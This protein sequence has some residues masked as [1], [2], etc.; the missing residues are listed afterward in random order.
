MLYNY[1]KYFLLLHRLSFF[2]KPASATSVNDFSTN[3]DTLKHY[4]DQKYVHIVGLNSVICCVQSSLVILETSVGYV[5]NATINSDEANYTIAVSQTMIV[6]RNQ[7]TTNLDENVIGAKG[8]NLSVVETKTILNAVTERQICIQMGIVNSTGVYHFNQRSLSTFLTDDP[9]ISY[10]IS[11]INENILGNVHCIASEQNGSIIMLTNLNESSYAPNCSN[12]ANLASQDA[13]QCSLVPQSIP[14]FQTWPPDAN[15]LNSYAPI[16]FAFFN[17]D[18]DKTHKGNLF[19]EGG[20]LWW[21]EGFGLTVGPAGSVL[22]Y[23]C[24]SLS[25][26]IGAAATGVLAFISA[27]SPIFPAV[28]NGT[29]GTF[30][31]TITY[32][33]IL[34]WDMCGMPIFLYGET[35]F[36]ANR[37]PDFPIS[38]QLKPTDWTYYPIGNGIAYG[39][40]YSHTEP[41]PKLYTIIDPIVIINCYDEANNVTVKGVPVYIN[42]VC[43]GGTG[44]TYFFAN[45]TYNMEFQS[46]GFDYLDVNGTIFNNN[47]ANVDFQGEESDTIIVT[48]YFSYVPTYTLTVD[49]YF[50]NANNENCSVNP[51]VYVDGELVGTAPISTA[52]TIGFHEIQV[53]DT[54][55]NDAINN[56][57]SLVQL[58]LNDCNGTHYFNNLQIIRFY[59]N[60][61]I[62]GCYGYRW[63]SE[64]GWCV[65]D[66]CATMTE[67]PLYPLPTITGYMNQETTGGH[68]YVNCY[69]EGDCPTFP[70]SIYVT[71]NYYDWFYVST[72]NVDNTSPQ[73]IDCGVTNETF[74]MI[75]LA[76]DGTGQQATLNVDALRVYP[77]RDGNLTLACGENGSIDP[78]AGL[79]EDLQAGSVFSATAYPDSGYWAVWYLNNQ[80]YSIDPSVSVIVDGN[81][82]LQV[83]FYASNASY[84][85]N[86]ESFEDYT[87]GLGCF[88]GEAFNCTTD[89]TAMSMTASVTGYLGSG[90]CAIYR[91]SDLSFVAKTQVRE[92]LDAGW[93]TF[94]FTNPPT[95]C[96][97]ETYIFVFAGCG[98]YGVHLCC[99]QYGE[100]DHGYAIDNW[101]SVDYFPELLTNEPYYTNSYRYSIYCTTLSLGN[102]PYYLAISADNGTTSPSG[103]QAYPWNTF[104]HV[105]ANPN[106]N[107]TFD[108]W[109]LDSSQTLYSNPVSLLMDGNHTLEAHFRP[110]LYYNLTVSCGTGGVSPTS[111]INTYVENSTVLMIAAP[112][113]GYMFDGWLLDDEPYSQ[114]SWLMVTMDGNHVLQANFVA[115]PTHT[116]TMSSGTGGTTS[117]SSGVHEYYENATVPVTAYPAANYTFSHWLLDNTQTIYNAS[118][119]VTMDTSHTLEAFFTAMPT[120]TLTISS[121]GNGTTDPSGICQYIENSQAQVTATAGEGSVFDHWLKDSQNAG[122]NQ[123]ITVTMDDDYTLEAVFR[124]L[125]YYDLAVSANGNGTTTGYALG[126]YQILE[127]STLQITAVPDEGFQFAGWLLDEEPYSQNL[128]VTL[129]MDG[130]H[131]LQ[132]NFETYYYICDIDSYS[133]YVTDPENLTGASNDDNWVCLLTYDAY[134]VS[135]TVVGVTDKEASG[136]VWV[137]GYVSSYDGGYLAVSVSEDGET[138]VQVSDQLVE[139]TTAGWI[140]CGVYPLPF[141]YVNLTLHDGWGTVSFDSVRIYPEPGASADWGNTAIFDDETCM[142]DN[143]CGEI[144]SCPANCTAQSLTAAVRSRCGTYV[145]YAIYRLSDWSLVAQ[146]QYAELP[147]GGWDDDPAWLTLNFTGS[148]PVLQCDVDYILVVS[149]LSDP[150]GAFVACYT[151]EDENGIDQY[152][153]WSTYWDGGLLIG[154]DYPST[155][156]SPNS[157]YNHY[158]IYATITPAT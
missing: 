141:N 111:G 36:Y 58:S 129:T 92:G 88:A 107:F 106:E 133:A 6:N 87:S 9:S 119:Y 110:L 63:I 73:W 84:I 114:D 126:N 62:E 25:S 121:S 2:L 23:M 147:A 11:E 7:T 78:E 148:P 91:L 54:V 99:D 34:F 143:I 71:Y 61:S 86:T 131:T 118:T 158:S 3:N 115:I 124:P 33:E 134:G 113:E 102:L 57:S 22:G 93:Y 56:F 68:V 26:A 32:W 138:W 66:Q 37:C 136:R 157:N 30:S 16:H 97:D 47:P 95:L 74:C 13:F 144:F 27:F 135:S 69:K 65:D 17:Y 35:G 51:D 85:G 19:L 104:A 146:T 156:T 75:K 72:V 122:S 43:I 154:F 125:I 89:C 8:Y 28:I 151:S 80:F 94:N 53:N 100:Q 18:Y 77:L 137:Y 140:D 109:L 130:N 149:S 103:T 45:G 127:N 76:A 112:N 5:Y 52:I 31:L 42:G 139:N 152:F 101:Y 105:I 20:Y 83:C 46:P 123:T 120:H 150:Y 60:A 81:C 49:N 1:F 39:I 153:G 40:I 116:L 142:A 145:S 55:W 15:Y 67:F 98:G 132:A 79:Y 108:Y 82:T 155:L 50:E 96:A 12:V 59:S 41:F 70:L 117:P 24:D 128:T 48:A 21:E 44:S 90:S 29:Q 14:L 38:W 4:L 10:G 64:I